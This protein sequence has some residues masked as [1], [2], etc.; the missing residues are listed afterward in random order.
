MHTILVVDDERT[1][2]EVIV[3]HLKNAG[4]AYKFLVANDGQNGLAIA[5]VKIP[6]MIITD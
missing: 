1:N 3:N 4:K 2:R 6:D 5:E